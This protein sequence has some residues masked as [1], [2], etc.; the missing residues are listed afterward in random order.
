MICLYCIVLLWLYGYG[1]QSFNPSSFRPFSAKVVTFG[2][3]SEKG[4][5]L[6][7][8]LVDSGDVSQSENRLSD[9]ANGVRE[10]FNSLLVNEQDSD[11]EEELEDEQTLLDREMM[12]EAIQLATS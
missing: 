8:T 10:S 12:K 3:N 7:G 1:V 9:S 2:V 5:T 4:F 11:E 6:L